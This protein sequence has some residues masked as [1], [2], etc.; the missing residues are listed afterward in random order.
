MFSSRGVGN[1]SFRTLQHGACKIPPRGARLCLGPGAPCEGQTA[2][3]LRAQRLR[4]RLDPMRVQAIVGI[5]FLSWIHARR[6]YSDVH[7]RRP[8][9]KGA[10]R[11][12]ITW[13]TVSFGDNKMKLCDTY[14]IFRGA[15][16][17]RTP[18]VYVRVR[19]CTDGMRASMAVAT[20][21]ASA[22]SS[23]ILTDV[24]NHAKRMNASATPSA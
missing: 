16:H 7:G 9:M 23:P 11:M 3:G 2:N 21:C 19:P 15:L 17:K 18:S 12:T 24:Q 14:V 13:H 1:L 20:V 8:F 10:L 5:L 22:E 4:V 6:A